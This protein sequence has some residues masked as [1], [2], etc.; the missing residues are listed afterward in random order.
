MIF[1]NIRGSEEEEEG[2][3]SNLRAY[4]RGGPRRKIQ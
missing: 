4:P 1:A 2:Y 3:D